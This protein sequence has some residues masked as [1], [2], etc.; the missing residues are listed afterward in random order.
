MCFAHIKLTADPT[1][2]GEIRS[3]TVDIIALDGRSCYKSTIS[4]VQENW[5]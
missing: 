4:C 2:N 5:S 1:S 3:C